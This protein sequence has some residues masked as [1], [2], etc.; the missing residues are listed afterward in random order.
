[1]NATTLK[2]VFTE[3]KD[4]NADFFNLRTVI[5]PNVD[6]DAT[7]FNFMMLPNDG[8]MAHL[9]LVGILYFTEVSSDSS[10]E[11]MSRSSNYPRGYTEYTDLYLRTRSI[12][13]RLPL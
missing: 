6:D 4:V 1:M 3:V 11:C 13:S 10:A 12:L 2:R 9:I 8:A 5:S 7:R